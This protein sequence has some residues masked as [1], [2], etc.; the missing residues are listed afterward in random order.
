MCNGADAHKTIILL[1]EVE[2][3][4]YQ[5]FLDGTMK[6]RSKQ[7][8]HVEQHVEQETRKQHVEVHVE[9]EIRKQHAEVHAVH[10]V[11][12]TLVLHGPKRSVD[13]GDK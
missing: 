10:N 5:T 2:K 4:H 6:R 9:R 1:Q 11:Q 3:W 7:V 8:L 13:A 12:W